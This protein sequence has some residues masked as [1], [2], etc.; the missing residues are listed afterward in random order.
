MADVPDEVTIREAAELLGKSKARVEQYVRD[1]RLK[2]SRT[3]G[4]L[5]L[6]LRADVLAFEPGPAGRP[7]KAAAEEPPAGPEKPKGKGGRKKKG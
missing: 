1:G 6:L 3:L 5:R 2:L 7:K 4:G